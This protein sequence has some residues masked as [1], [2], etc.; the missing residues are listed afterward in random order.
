MSETYKIGR[1]VFV[2]TGDLNY[3][4]RKLRRDYSNYEI[5]NTR[6]WSDGTSTYTLEL[7]PKAKS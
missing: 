1:E 7:K 4:R 5:T 3:L 6:K 2:S